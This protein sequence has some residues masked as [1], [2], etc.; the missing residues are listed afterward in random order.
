[1]FKS[2]ALTS[3]LLSLAGAVYL[4]PQ[5][6]RCKPKGEPNIK[7]ITLGKNNRDIGACVNK[8]LNDDACVGMEFREPKYCELHYSDIQKV[9]MIRRS[10]FIF[11]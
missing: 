7:S 9:S 6:G 2:I 1:M 11:S 3:L 4:Q 8:C 10:N 5:S